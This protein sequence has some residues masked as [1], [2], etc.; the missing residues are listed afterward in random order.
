MY[1][2]LALQSLFL[3][4]NL[5]YVVRSMQ[6]YGSSQLLPEEWVSRHRALVNMYKTNYLMVWK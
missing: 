1:K 4:N 5:N 6:S 3:M 2:T